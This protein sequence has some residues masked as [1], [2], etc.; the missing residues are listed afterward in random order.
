MLN[1]DFEHLRSTYGGALSVYVGASVARVRLESL[2]YESSVARVR[3]ESLT[4]DP[5][6]RI[7]DRNE[8]KRGLT[9]RCT[10]RWT[11]KSGPV[12]KIE[13]HYQKGEVMMARTRKIHTA[14]FKAKVALAAVREMETASQ[15]ASLHGVHPT[16]IHQWKR[17]LLEGAEGVFNAGAGAKRS[18]VEEECATAELY[19]QI[20]RLKMELEWLKKKAERI[21]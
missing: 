5:P 2:T 20:G 11:P 9:R 15:L 17:Q 6:C 19:E 3:L 18:R 8:V 21:G 16:Q 4:Y 10:L 1:R 12:V 13:N 7:A 14:A